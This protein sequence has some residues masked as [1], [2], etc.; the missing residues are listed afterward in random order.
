MLITGW[1]VVFR[2]LCCWFKNGM[3]GITKMCSGVWTGEDLV[4]HMHLSSQQQ[5]SINTCLVV[6][7]GYCFLIYHPINPLWN[8]IVT[9]GHAKRTGS[10]TNLLITNSQ[11]MPSRVKFIILIHHNGACHKSRTAHNSTTNVLNEPNLAKHLL[12]HQKI[13]IVKISGHNIRITHQPTGG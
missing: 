11:S 8:I 2:G 12:L 13:C 5:W 3:R 10:T 6:N 9:C 7:V 4:G 1:D